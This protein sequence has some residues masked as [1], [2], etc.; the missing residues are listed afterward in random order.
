MINKD[1]IIYKN[2]KKFNNDYVCVMRKILLGDTSHWERG[3]IIKISEYMKYYES[4][5]DDCNCFQKT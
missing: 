4:D 2:L 5:K 1:F 3:E